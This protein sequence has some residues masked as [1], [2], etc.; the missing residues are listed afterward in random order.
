[1]PSVASAEL[2]DRIANMSQTFSIRSS[3]LRKKNLRNVQF[4]PVHSSLYLLVV[5]K[6]KRKT[7]SPFYPFTATLHSGLKHQIVSI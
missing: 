6:E 1:M 5:R 7:Q 3:Y 2:R 4:R